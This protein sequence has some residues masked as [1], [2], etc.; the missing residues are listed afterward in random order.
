MVKNVYA[1]VGIVCYS[2]VMV[3][4]IIG[5]FRN[6]RQNHDNG[7]NTQP[8]SSNQP[9]NDHFETQDDSR[10]TLD[11]SLRIYFPLD[12]ADAHSAMPQLLLET[13]DLPPMYENC[14]SYEECSQN[15]EQNKTLTKNT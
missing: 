1:L 12:V 9:S 14:P 2:I 5:S 6:E 7:I 4:L 13:E 15:I 8:A 11:E 3:I 10:T